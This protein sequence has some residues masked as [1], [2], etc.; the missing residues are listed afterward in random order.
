M[1]HDHTILDSQVKAAFTKLGMQ[2]PQ[3]MT[4]SQYQLRNK[5]QN[6]SVKHLDDA[7]MQ[8]QIKS[9]EKALRM[10]TP[11]AD[12]G[13]KLQDSNPTIVELTE[14]VRPGVR[15][16]PAA[17]T[18]GGQRDWSRAGA[19]RQHE[20]DRRLPF[21]RTEWARSN[22]NENIRFYLSTNGI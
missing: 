10:V 19:I 3:P 1:V 20:V 13:E 5:L 14:E 8:E 2:M 4:S 11:V 21:T 15:A 7:Y 18:D 9:H 22:A 6:E 16:A 17:S 12:Q